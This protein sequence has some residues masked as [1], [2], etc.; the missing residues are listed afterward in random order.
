MIGDDLCFSSNMSRKESLNIDK[1]TDIHIRKLIPIVTPAQVISEYKLSNDNVDF[2]LKN[3]EEV[4]AILN[5]KDDRL[6]CI[7]GPCSIHDPKAAIDYAKR[8]AKLSLELKDELLIIMRVY[9]EKPRTT[10]GWKGLINDPDLNG[11]YDLAKGVRV[12]RK[13]L[14]DILDNHLGIATEF[15]DPI[16]PQYTADTVSWGAIGAR[17]T[18][19]PVHRQLVSGL[20]M[21]VGFKNT[22]SGSLKAAVDACVAAK[23]TH[24]FFSVNVDGQLV[25]AETDGNPDVH[26]ILRGS[27]DGPN[28]QPEFVDQALVEA[29][30][31]DAPNATKHGVII[32]AA[33]GNSDK[34]EI[35][36]AVVIREIAERIASGEKGISGI[37]M[38]S[39][40]EGGKQDAAPLS[41][42][43]YGKSVTDPCVDW[44]TT[45]ELLKLLAKSVQSFRKN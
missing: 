32:D 28:Y 36:E 24:T 43:V 9:F 16:T 22:V 34:N 17:T 44:Q 37:M 8:L 12:A 23:I 3:R 30:L 26:I 45:S 4:R 18:E 11:N 14:L 13:L 42:I 10:I 29:R 1:T 31:S 7:I 2:V 40:I 21:P 35:K 33:H 38:E 5:G 15:L 27:A 20:S 25:S 39:F 19:S 6:L 41:T